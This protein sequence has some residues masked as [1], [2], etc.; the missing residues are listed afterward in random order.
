[1]AKSITYYPNATANCTNCG[2]VYTFG[3]TVEKSS[4]EICAS[5]HRFYTGE[6]TFVDTAGRID[7]FQARIA[8]VVVPVASIKT[9]GARKTRLS[10]ADLLE[11]DEKELE[12]ETQN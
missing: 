4:V 7:K 6:N 5:C 1:M 9:K 11:G 12:E 8:K 3:S 10:L 2:S